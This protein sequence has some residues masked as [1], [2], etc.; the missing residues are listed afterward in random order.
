MDRSFDVLDKAAQN[1]GGAVGNLMGAGLGL[2]LG[3]GVGN[4]MSNISGNLNT[5]GTPQVPPMQYYVLINNQQNGPLSFA[6]LSQLISDVR[7]NKQ[8]LVWKTGMENWVLITEIPEV[9]NLLN[10]TPP[11]PPAIKI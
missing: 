1:E 3:V 11:P 2:G 7:I 8:S 10:Q 4:Q 6:Q 9:S 5:N